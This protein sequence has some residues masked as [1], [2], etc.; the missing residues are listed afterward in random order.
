M[1]VHNG[2]PLL[3]TFAQSAT[4][5]APSG[6]QSAYAASSAPWDTQGRFFQ[7]GKPVGGNPH[8]REF[9]FPD[10][11]KVVSRAHEPQLA[12]SDLS[13]VEQVATVFGMSTAGATMGFVV[14][15]PG[16]AAAGGAA[17]AAGGV[18]IAN[19]YP[20]DRIWQGYTLDYYNKGS[21]SPF[22]TQSM[23]AWDTSWGRTG[24]LSRQKDAALWPDYADGNPDGDWTWWKWK[25]GNAPY[26]T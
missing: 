26:R 25:S 16:G 14:G 24:L 23:Y 18:G 4:Q 2:V 5:G 20:Y 11:S 8:V 12:T 3:F 21:A 19:S 6:Y 15:G 10:G 1:Q 13:K 22:Y 17:G 7:H 9:D